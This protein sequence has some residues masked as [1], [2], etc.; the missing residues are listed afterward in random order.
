MSRFTGLKK[1][2]EGVRRVA[3][4]VLFLDLLEDPAQDHSNDPS[5]NCHH[6]GGRLLGESSC[7]RTTLYESTAKRVSARK[8]QPSHRQRLCVAQK[9]PSEPRPRAPL[10]QVPLKD[11][12][13][14]WTTV[15]TV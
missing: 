2:I 13:V 1:A 6:L 15:R 8:L 9:K 5:D 7:S 4:M 10:D 11:S 14:I 12:A 3:H